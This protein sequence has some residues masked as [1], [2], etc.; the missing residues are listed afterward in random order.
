MSGLSKCTLTYDGREIEVN[1]QSVDISVD[2]SSMSIGYIGGA[3]DSNKSFYNYQQPEIVI[4]G[5]M[6][7]ISIKEKEMCTEKLCDGYCEKE[8][9]ASEDTKCLAKKLAT[10]DLTDEERLVKKYNVFKDDGTL[11]VTG[12]EALLQI[13]SDVYYDEIIEKLE[14]LE[15]LKTKT[16]VEE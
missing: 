8:G 13:L 10:L 11:T 9:Y 15:K 5:L 2:Y 4:K 16:P 3:L 6:N 14:S 12:K 1:I 7:E